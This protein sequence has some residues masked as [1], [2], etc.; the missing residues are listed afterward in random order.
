M[1]FMACWW[2]PAVVAVVWVLDKAIHVG[3]RAIAAGFIAVVDD[4]V[5]L[6][7]TQ[8]QGLGVLY[9]DSAVCA[10]IS[11]QLG[12]GTRAGEPVTR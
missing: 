12:E 2:L 3:F 1:P 10:V 11:E 8:E 7:W 4:D 5:A 6:T 9:V